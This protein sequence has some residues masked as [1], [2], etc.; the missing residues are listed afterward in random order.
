M[1]SE[2]GGRV[3]RAG[4]NTS[5][6]NLAARPS[7]CEAVPRDNLEQCTDGKMMDD[8]GVD[9]S[10][11]ELGAEEVPRMVPVGVCA[12][13]PTCETIA[14]PG[15]VR[16][17]GPPGASGGCG[18]PGSAMV[19]GTPRLSR[20]GRFYGA[21]RVGDTTGLSTCGV[22]RR[23]EVDEHARLVAYDPGVVARWRVHRV[24]G[25]DFL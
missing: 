22:V 13:S 8:D 9:V 16:T 3:K 15:K 19:A 12:I 21:T 2:D 25:A 23:R 20:P 10:D 7:A 18:P 6:D 14:A 5:P 17:P 24:A 11:L 1:L 4:D